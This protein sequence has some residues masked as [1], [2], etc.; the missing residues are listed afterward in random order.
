M[1][2]KTLLRIVGALMLLATSLFC[3]FGFLASFEPG[4]GFIW[5]VGYGTLA[6]GFLFGA[7]ALLR[8]GGK[9]AGAADGGVNR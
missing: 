1:R 2:L 7:V 6:C 4:N 5:K 9:N 8:C 3:T